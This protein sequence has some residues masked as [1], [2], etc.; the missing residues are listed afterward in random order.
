MSFHKSKLKRQDTVK[1]FKHA[2]KFQDD[3][4]QDELDIDIVCPQM[5]RLRS[6]MLE[7]KCGSFLGSHLVAWKPR[8]AV[9]LMKLDS[10]HLL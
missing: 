7:K 3:D 2:M 4:D 8:L 6:G 1:R 9:G 5:N 10:S